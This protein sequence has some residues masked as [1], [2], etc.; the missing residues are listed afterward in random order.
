L[1]L[2][3][4]AES[5]TSD[6]TEPADADA[7]GLP[8]HL[9]EGQ[10]RHHPVELAHHLDHLL[11]L[12]AKTGDAH[13][14]E[15]ATRDGDRVIALCKRDGDVLLFPYDFAFQLHGKYATL[16]PPWYS[17]MA[18]GMLLG[19]VSRL[20]AATHEARHLDAARGLFQS[21]LT[22]RAVGA[23]WVSAVD[24][25][26]YLWIEEY[27]SAPPT[28][29]L[30]GYLAAIFGLYDYWVEAGDER[31]LVLL[32]AAVSS[33]RHYLPSYRR[34]GKLSRYGLLYPDAIKKYHAVHILQ[35]GWLARS[36]GDDFFAQTAAQLTSDRAP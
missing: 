22:K 6:F 31:A 17:G 24:T 8:R 4:R 9:I 32:R 20:Y 5:D 34:E 10:L 18:Q 15:R 19:A 11:A 1:P 2:V 26:G 12:Y 27:P 23:S 33:V 21:L 29:V 7:D 28:H 16:A 35:L 3:E 13:W 30:N 36:T 14:L 25:A